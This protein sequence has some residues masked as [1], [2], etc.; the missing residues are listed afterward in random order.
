MAK[1][2]S[3]FSWRTWNICVARAS[4][5]AFL[6]GCHFKHWERKY[7]RLS[8][9]EEDCRSFSSSEARALGESA[10]SSLWTLSRV[11]V[12]SLLVLAAFLLEPLPAALQAAG[13]ALHGVS[14]LQ[15]WPG[16]AAWPGVSAAGL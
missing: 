15:C 8:G 3:F 6:S 16:E 7:R 1:N 4:L 13:P 11:G 10:S 5:P 2:H 14:E 12:C 9:R